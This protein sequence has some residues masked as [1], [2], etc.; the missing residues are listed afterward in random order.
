MIEWLDHFALKLIEICK[1]FL[2]IAIV[3]IGFQFFVIRRPLTNLKKT[4]SGFILV[5]LGMA[6]FLEGLDTALFPL[7]NLMVLQLTAPEFLPL[8]PMGQAI[9]WQAYKWIYLYAASIGFAAALAEPALLA[10][11]IKIEHI[12]GGAIRAWGLRFAVAFGA[13]FGLALGAFR[14]VLGIELHHFIIAGYCIVIIQTLAA[15]KAIIGLAYDSGV[16]TTTMVTVPMITALGAGLAQTV[17]GRNPLLDGFGLIVYASLF[18][19]ITVLGYAQ[20]AHWLNRD[21]QLSKS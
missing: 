16:V 11:A 19:I 12:S 15:P 5:L 2:P 14:L 10:V 6:C 13:G 9:N 18:P 8:D 17:P 21:R 4:L 20:I 7:G 1:N 3:I